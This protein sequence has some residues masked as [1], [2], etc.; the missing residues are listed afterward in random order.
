MAVILQIHWEG[1]TPEQ[2]DDLGEKVNWHGEPPE[3]GIFHAA[4]FESDGLHV[5]DVWESRE[6]FHRFFED[7]VLS[8]LSGDLRRNRPSLE[9]RQLHAISNDEAKRMKRSA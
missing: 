9:F 7:Q 4:W 6:H 8:H 2:Y 3:G 5:F 1:V